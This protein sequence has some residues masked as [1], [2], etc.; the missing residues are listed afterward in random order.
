MLMS[1]NRRLTWVTAYRLDTS[2]CGMTIYR[3]LT[4]TTACRQDTTWRR[5]TTVNNRQLTLELLL[6]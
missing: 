2:N 5:M 3:L 4:W 1:I 6:G